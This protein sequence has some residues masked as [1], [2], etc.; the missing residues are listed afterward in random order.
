MILRGVMGLIL[1]ITQNECEREREK[2]G[3]RAKSIGERERKFVWHAKEELSGSS[4]YV[5]CTYVFKI[6]FC[7]GIFFVQME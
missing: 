4:F 1:I 7:H 6:C 2:D 3:E 5:V